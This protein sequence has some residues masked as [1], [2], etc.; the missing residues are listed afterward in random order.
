MERSAEGS[1]G[2]SEGGRRDEAHHFVCGGD[3]KQHDTTRKLERAA[4]TMA[5]IWKS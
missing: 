4:V 2:A 1:E 3:T 5:G